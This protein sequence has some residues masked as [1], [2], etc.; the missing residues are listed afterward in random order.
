METAPTDLKKAL[1]ANAAA[2]TQWAD[3]T[4]IARRDFIS[5]IV[6]A[7]QIETRTRRVSV[8][9]DKLVAG[10]R[11]PCCYAIVPMGLYK[12]LDA[13]PTAKEKWKLLTPD[14][15]RDFTGWVDAGKDAATRT[16]RIKK[17]VALIAAN[18]HPPAHD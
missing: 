6:S 11:R 15:R 18:K 7:K 13:A 9:I 3:L 10:K 5:W 8:A 16:Q 14:A 2:K 17:A 4:P 12:A 1:A